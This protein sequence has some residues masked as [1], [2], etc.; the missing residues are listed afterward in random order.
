MIKRTVSEA[1]SNLRQLVDQ[2]EH[3]SE[4]IALERYGQTAAVLVSL[5]DA[6]LLERIEDE[7]DMI[8][9]RKALKNPDFIPL[10][11]VKAELNL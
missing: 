10:E 4:R 9:V 11:Q 1:R 8:E 2:V 6:E 7:L 5:A 3:H